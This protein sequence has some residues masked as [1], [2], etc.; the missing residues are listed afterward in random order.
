MS[1]EALISVFN[2]SDAVKAT[3]LVALALADYA[4][5]DGSN[6]WPAVGTIARK[7]RVDERTVQRA[8]RWLERNCEIVQTGTTK[9]GV[10]IYHLTTATALKVDVALPSAGGD[11]L[12]PEDLEVQVTVKGS[13]DNVPPED[14]GQDVTP[15]ATSTREATPIDPGLPLAV[16]RWIG[17]NARLVDAATAREILSTNYGLEGVHL[18]LAVTYHASRRNACA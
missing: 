10:A 18:E 6:A 12:T 1:L 5:P 17:K 8:L 11:K 3:R 2:N 15:G 14:S 13:G 4:H 7:A 16:Q 9:N